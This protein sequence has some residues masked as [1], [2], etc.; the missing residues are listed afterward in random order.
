MRKIK[1][2]NLED[3][4]NETEVSVITKPKRFRPP[5]IPVKVVVEPPIIEHHL[6]QFNQ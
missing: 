2:S 6:N 4:V 3:T 1:V 5:R